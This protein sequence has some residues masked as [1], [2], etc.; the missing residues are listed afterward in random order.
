M[1]MS[2][3]K[4]PLCDCIAMYGSHHPECPVSLEMHRIRGTLRT[5]LFA[6]DHVEWDAHDGFDMERL[7]DARSVAR[8]VLQEVE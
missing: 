4:V 7:D 1:L 6:V 5:L 8:H 2:K 3:L